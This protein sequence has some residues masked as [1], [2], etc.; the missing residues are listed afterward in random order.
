MR[1]FVLYCN[2][3]NS[4]ACLVRMTWEF[5]ENWI[6]LDVTECFSD[7]VCLSYIICFIF[8]TLSGF[9]YKVYAIS[10]GQGPRMD[11]S[12]M[13][14]YFPWSI[15]AGTNHVA[16]LAR[17]WSMGSLL[18]V[19]AEEGSLPEIVFLRQRSPPSTAF[20]PAI[21]RTGT[22]CKHANILKCLPFRTLKHLESLDW[23]WQ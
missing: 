22:I 15:L 6:I 17:K 3:H 1:N 14:R 16:L 7:Q 21:F 4:S 10:P 8:P 12:S 13:W 5:N 23:R 18:C 20:L 11:N 9:W 19:M 2:R